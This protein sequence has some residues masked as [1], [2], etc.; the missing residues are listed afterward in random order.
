MLDRLINIGVGAFLA[1]A[2][3]SNTAE[4]IHMLLVGGQ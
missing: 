2:V 1:I 3:L 4:I